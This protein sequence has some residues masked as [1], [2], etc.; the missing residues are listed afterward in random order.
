MFHVRKSEKEFKYFAHTLVEH[1]DKIKRIAF[2]G[3]DRDKAQQGFISPLTRCTFLPCKKHVENEISRKMS[4]LGLNN[5][6]MEVLKDVFG[7]NKYQEKDI[8]D[9][10]D[11]EEFVV[12]VN[13]VVD[14]WDSLEKCL[15]PGKE[16]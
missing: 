6:K 4:D 15:Y 7:C 3:G 11:E 5:M 1:N 14:K 8:V 9:S 13:S 2:V 12:N 10:A 16:P